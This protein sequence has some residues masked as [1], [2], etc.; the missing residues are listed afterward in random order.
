MES[1][2]WKIKFYGV[3][4]ST[5]V[6]ESEMSHFGGNTTCFY[7]DL[8]VKKPDEKIIVIF[9]AGTGI[10]NLGKDIAAGKIP[11]TEYILLHISHFHWDHIQGF[12]FFEPAYYPNQKIALFSPHYAGKEASELKE[13]F[14]RQ[15][16]SE[17]FP[18]QLDNMGAD[19]RFYTTEEFQRTLSMDKNVKFLYRRHQHPGGAFSYRLDGYGKSI[20]ICSDLEHGENIDPEVVKFCENADLLIH[21]AQYTDEQLKE[22]RGRGHSSFTQAIE[23]AERANVKQLYLTHHDPDHDDT[24]LLN[25]EEECQKR[26]PNCSLAR[27][28]MEVII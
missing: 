24:F 2:V 11:L 17:H 21:D 8:L 20:V 12:P 15:M 3:R 28:G 5:P 9:D 18:V 25:I 4:G 22:Y 13:V 7:L 27:E 14:G 23:V 1:A 6:C 19:M 10:R 26:F 16:H